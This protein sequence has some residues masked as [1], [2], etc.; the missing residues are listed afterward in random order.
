M[1]EDFVKTEFFHD[2]SD[3]KY[4]IKR[5]QD[6]EPILNANKIAQ[7]DGSNGYS[8]SR[9]LRRVAS[10]PLVVIEQWMKEDGVNILALTGDEKQKYFRRKLNDPD[11]KYFRTDAGGLVL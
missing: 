2:E 3:D 9:D 8:K 6:I 10:I 5:E 4:I 11:N 7:N 1:S